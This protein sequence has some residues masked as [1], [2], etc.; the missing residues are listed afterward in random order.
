MT[1]I[2]ARPRLSRRA[3]M[4]NVNPHICVRAPTSSSAHLLGEWLRHAPRD[5]RR[6]S[7]S[8]RPR[9]NAECSCQTAASRACDR[10]SATIQGSVRTDRRVRAHA[11]RTAAP[12]PNVDARTSH[13]DHAAD[14]TRRSRASRTPSTSH[15]A[16]G[17]KQPPTIT[18]SRSKRFTADARP[19]PRQLPASLRLSSVCGSPARA[20]WTRSDAALLASAPDPTVIPARRAIASCP[21]YVSRHPFE[22]HLHG[23]PS[24]ST[25][26]CPNSPP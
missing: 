6:R 5:S 9:L 7:G 20:R 13:G 23:G 24:G 10:R 16:R 1:G 21:T 25:V 17:P 4:F 19:A 8:S 12:S 3:P 15:G 22:P 11:P 2:P 18:A 26:M 14:N